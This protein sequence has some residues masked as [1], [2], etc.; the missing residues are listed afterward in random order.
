MGISLSDGGPGYYWVRIKM[1]SA[2]LL[3][4][5]LP[6]TWGL[7]CSGQARRLPCLHPH[8][9][10]VSRWTY[11]QAD[12]G[13]HPPPQGNPSHPLPNQASFR[14]AV[15][16]SLSRSSRL[17]LPEPFPSLG[18]H[19]PQAW[20]VTLLRTGLKCCDYVTQHTS[21]LAFYSSSSYVPISSVQIPIWTWLCHS[22]FSLLIH[23]VC[24]LFIGELSGSFPIFEFFLKSFANF[25]V[26]L[27]ISIT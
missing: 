24:E 9:A 13:V 6:W 27:C 11:V 14:T 5:R 26:S 25:P 17:P 2:E 16:F 22:P 19:Y 1:G 7:I 23:C 10:L 20:C 18:S 3:Q 8:F 15:T 21:L 12:G 4:L